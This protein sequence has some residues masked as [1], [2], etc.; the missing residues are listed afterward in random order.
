[1]TKTAQ[2]QKQTLQHREEEAR[3]Q[4]EAEKYAKGTHLRKQADQK[5]KEQKAMA[6]ARETQVKAQ[7]DAKAQYVDARTKRMDQI[8]KINK[9]FK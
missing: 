3:L 4:A 7:N 9:K 5:I 6:N 2:Q 1:M 8:A